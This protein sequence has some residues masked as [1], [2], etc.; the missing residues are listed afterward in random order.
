[1]PYSEEIS[2]YAVKVFRRRSYVMDEFH[3]AG[4]ETYCAMEVRKTSQGGRPSS[5]KAC[6]VPIFAT[7]LFVRCS[8]K[9]IVE[10]KYSHNDLL[11]YYRDISTGLPGRINEREMEVFRMVTSLAGPED[12]SFFGED[13]PEFHKGDKV[14]ITGGTFEGAEGFIKRVGR[15]RKV[16]VCITGVAAVLIS[17]INPDFLERLPEE[18]RNS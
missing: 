1:M 11:M 3:A 13:R 18:D 14:R 7:L 2:W 17:N 15:D 10:Y 16:L 9:Y 5:G 4:W 12:V 6:P 8:E